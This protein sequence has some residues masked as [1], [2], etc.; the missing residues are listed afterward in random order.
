MSPWVSASQRA[1][2]PPR[3]SRRASTRACRARWAAISPRM[4]DS[5]NFFEPTA[6]TGFGARVP[7]HPASINRA[8]RASRGVTPPPGPLP[9]AERGRKH[10]APPLRFGEG[11]GGRGSAVIGHLRAALGLDGASGGRGRRAAPE[12]R[13]R[14][15]LNNLPLAQ[16]DHTVGE[17]RSLAEVVGHEHHRFAE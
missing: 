3:A 2:V 10:F 17:E 9:E 13:R 12:V 15:L 8:T 1:G 6:T 16:Q 11:V 5:V 14:S 4:T 7:E